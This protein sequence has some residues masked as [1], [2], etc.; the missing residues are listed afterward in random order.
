MR[1]ASRLAHQAVQLRKDRTGTVG[2]IEHLTATDLAQ[3]DPRSRKSV[4]LAL[5]G[6]QPGT[7]RTLDLSQVESFIYSPKEKGQYR[8][9][10]AAEERS[11]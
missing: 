4:E 11:Q 8:A 5:D 3:Q 6:S 10:R 9:A 1:H 7:G 2:L